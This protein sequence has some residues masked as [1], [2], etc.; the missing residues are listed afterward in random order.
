MSLCQLPRN[1]VNTSP[2]YFMMVL[3]NVNTSNLQD[4]CPFAQFIK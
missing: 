4:L 1:M 2:R 3:N